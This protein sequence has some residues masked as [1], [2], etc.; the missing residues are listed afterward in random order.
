MTFAAFATMWLVF[1][2]IGILHRANWENKYICITLWVILGIFPPVFY[3]L[4]AM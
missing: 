4:M 2:T 1:W 3:K